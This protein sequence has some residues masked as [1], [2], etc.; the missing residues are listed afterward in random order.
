M[1]KTIPT[2]FHPISLHYGTVTGRRVVTRMTEVRE[3]NNASKIF[4]TKLVRQ[5]A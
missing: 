2:Y 4:E 1:P 5:Y 3:M